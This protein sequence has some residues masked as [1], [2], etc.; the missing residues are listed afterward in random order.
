[1]ESSINSEYSPDRRAELKK[2]LRHRAET[3][4]NLEGQE[5]MLLES[6]RRLATEVTNINDRIDNYKLIEAYLAKYADERQAQVYRQIE[7]TVTEG[8]RTVFN[9]D[10]RL[11]VETKMVGSRSETVFNIVSKTPEGELSTSIMDSRGGGVAAIVGFLVQAVLVLLTPSLRPILFLDESFR[12]VS[13][14]YQAPL[15]EFIQDLCQRTGLQVVLVTHQ[16]TIAEYASNWYSF[17]QQNGKTKITKV[18]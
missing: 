8:L 6:Q 9:E 4:A 15:G 14:E 18:V 1:M 13:E 5:S 2:E 16:P 3:V 7:N 12:N 17:S 11:E 10:L